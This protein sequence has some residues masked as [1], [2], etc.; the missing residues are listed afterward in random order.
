[1]GIIG[2]VHYRFGLE[3]M[4][5]KHGVDMMIWAHEHSYERLW[6]LYNYVVL[7]GSYEQPYVN[8]NAPVHVTTGSAVSFYS[9]WYLKT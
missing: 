9:F 6:P 7:N 8:P 2:T 5:Y 4:M 3:D 1:M